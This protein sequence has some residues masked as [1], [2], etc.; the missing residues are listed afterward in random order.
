MMRLIRATVA[1]GLAFAACPALADTSCVSDA[2]IRERATALGLTLKAMT[3][4]EN[5][6]EIAKAVA[7]FNAQPGE[8]VSE[9]D[10]LIVMDLADGGFYM[11]FMSGG[12]SCYGARIHP[13]A[14]MAARRA[15]F[16]TAL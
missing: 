1:L 4:G 3:V 5:P 10:G 9:I 16:G 11:A 15:I 6:R 12:Q 14:A 8:I 13:V 7:F 2:F